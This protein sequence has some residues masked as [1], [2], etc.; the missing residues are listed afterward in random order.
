MGKYGIALED[1]AALRIRLGG[2]TI[3]ALEAALRR[4]PLP[5]IAR[6]AQDSI[7]LD[8]LALA[9]DEI[10]LVA[11]SLDWAAGQTVGSGG[12]AGRSGP[13]EPDSLDPSAPGAPAHG[14]RPGD[15]PRPARG[16]AADG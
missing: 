16:S 7:Y 4:A 6:V 9:E 1:N 8:V 3:T 13:R 2:A 14:L 11:D 5:V 12:S 15:A 10:D